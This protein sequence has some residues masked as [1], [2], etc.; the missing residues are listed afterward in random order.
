VRR[1]GV[2][3]QGLGYQPVA[4]R[5][6]VDRPFFGLRQQGSKVGDA[7]F[8]RRYRS[9]VDRL[10][11]RPF[12]RRCLILFSIHVEQNAGLAVIALQRDNYLGR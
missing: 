12:A 5:T 10:H 9:G 4:A 7:S 8:K 11:V 2:R 6:L 3:D 1:A